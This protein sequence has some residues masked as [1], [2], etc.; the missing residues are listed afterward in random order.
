M[1]ITAVLLPL[2]VSLPANIP[3]GSN[4]LFDFAV[5][6]VVFG[7]FPIVTDVLMAILAGLYALIIGLYCTV[8]RIPKC[9]EN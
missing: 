6:C 3:A 4:I 8:L 5:R 2:F 1:A 9:R 7:F